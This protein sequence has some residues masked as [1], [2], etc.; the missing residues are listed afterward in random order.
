MNPSPASQRHSRSSI[1]MSLP[2][3][4]WVRYASR[5]RMIPSS[6]TKNG[7]DGTA[8]STRVNCALP[9][10]TSWDTFTSETVNGTATRPAAG[11]SG[12]TLTR[13]RFPRGESTGSGSIMNPSPA[14]QRHSRS[15]IAM[16]LPAEGWVRYASRSRRIPSSPTKIGTGGKAIST[17][18]NCALPQAARF[19]VVSNAVNSIAI[20]RSAGKPSP[21]LT[22]MLFRRAESESIVSVSAAFP[23]GFHLGSQLHS[24]SVLSLPSGNWVM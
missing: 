9:P 1:A 7:A 13:I 17:R 20:K 15:S 16:S 24:I 4:G 6:P 11:F 2:A 14:S 18:T 21:T 19:A 12:S 22:R 10:P 8:I 3:E 23:S 5:S